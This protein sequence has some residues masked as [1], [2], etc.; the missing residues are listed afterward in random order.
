MHNLFLYLLDLPEE[1]LEDEELVRHIE[2]NLRII[3]EGESGE[4]T[5]KDYSKNKFV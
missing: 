3:R 1:V 4:K 2:Q 5:E